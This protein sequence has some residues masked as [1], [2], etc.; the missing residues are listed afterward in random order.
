MLVMYSSAH[1]NNR[2]HNNYNTVQDRD[3]MRTDCSKTSFHSSLIEPR[4]RND[5]FLRE[6]YKQTLSHFHSLTLERC[7]G[8]TMEL[9]KTYQTNLSEYMTKDHGQ[10]ENTFSLSQ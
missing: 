5:T 7:R 4:L 1:G 6:C 10:I 8:N 9:T 2:D 3:G